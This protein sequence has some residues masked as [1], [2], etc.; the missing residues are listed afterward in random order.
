M[1]SFFAI[2]F[3]FALNG[4]CAQRP[5]TVSAGASFDLGVKGFGVNDAGFGLYGNVNLLAKKPLQLR[6]E[7]GVDKLIGDKLLEI[8]SVG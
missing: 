5:L 3:L 4:V 1:R 2:A 7:G 6:V 8:D